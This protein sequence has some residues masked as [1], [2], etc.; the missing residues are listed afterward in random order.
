[1]RSI[2][3]ITIPVATSNIVK[4]KWDKACLTGCFLS[5]E[6]CLLVRHVPPKSAT[7]PCRSTGPVTTVYST[8]A[9]D[10]SAVG[11]FSL[12]HSAVGQSAVR[13]SIRREP[14]HRGP[15][16]RQPIRRQPSSRELFRRMPT[17]RGPVRSWPIQCRQANPR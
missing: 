14:V 16:R 1:M 5:S 9:V 10:Q 13:G 8:V 3:S 7:Y 17:H 15:I 6:T 4:H 2:H 11:Q 12:G